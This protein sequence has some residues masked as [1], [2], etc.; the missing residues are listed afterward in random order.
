MGTQARIEQL[1]KLR[2]ESLHAGS[3][4]AVD[5]QHELGKLTARERLEILLDKGS[6][7]EIDPFV[8]HQ[9]TGFGIEEKR[10]LG[11][12]VITGYGTIDGRTVFVYAEDFTVFGEPGRRRGQ[13]DLQADGHG[14]PGRGT[15]HR[16][17]RL[18]RARIQ[19]GWLRS[20]ATAESSSG[21]C[22][23]RGGAPD[24]GDHGPVRGG[25]VYSPAI[26]DFVIQ[27]D[28]TSH[29]FITGPDVIKAV[30]GEDVT[31]EE[32]GGARTHASKSGVTHF[33]FPTGKDAL[34]A[35]RY[36]LSFIPQNNMELPPYFA[37]PTTPTGSST[38]STR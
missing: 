22:G 7:N 38:L 14:A 12:A 3:Q 25:A 37:P 2:E 31:M 13:Q 35:V 16:P 17:Q 29:M 23:H 1:R 5:R 6:F 8:R 34:E 28:K 27:V 11:D 20:T 32:L 18:G 19:E 26:T 30:T 10:P 4:R 33:V 21:T 15:D 36:L 9:A 24:L